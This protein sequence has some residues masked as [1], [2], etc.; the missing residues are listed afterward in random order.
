MTQTTKVLRL[1][2]KDAEGKK[3]ALTLSNAKDGL[4]EEQV[5]GAMT[6]ISQ[7]GLFEKE[8]VAIYDSIQ[9]AAY[10]ERN[11]TSIFDDAADTDNSAK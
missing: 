5:R 6:K 11:T 9:S 4:S 1:T 7:A 8:G 3:K 2:F 10:I